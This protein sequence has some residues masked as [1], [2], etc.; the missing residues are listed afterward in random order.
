[1]LEIKGLHATV[2]DKPILK[3]VDLSIGDGQ[4][5]GIMG[6]NGSGKS[7]LA[8]VIAGDPSYVVTAGEVL[9]DGVNILDMSPDER[10]RAGVFLAFQYPLEIP[11]VT[12]ANFLRSAVTA[13]RGQDRSCR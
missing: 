1:M 7:T 11:G 6:P 2:E 10:A 4:V 8:R 9:Y 3:G 12:V 13:V 5:H